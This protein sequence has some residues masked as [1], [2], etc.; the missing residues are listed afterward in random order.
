MTT[1][2]N[3]PS[4]PFGAGALNGAGVPGDLPDVMELTRLANEF[5]AN[6]PGYS[7]P[8]GPRVSGKQPAEVDVP[9]PGM[10]N[11]AAW[12]ASPSPTFGAPYNVP[13]SAAGMHVAPSFLDNRPAGIPSEVPGPGAVASYPGAGAVHSIAPEGPYHVPPS[14]SVT[15]FSRTPAPT[16]VA[17]KGP[18]G[19]PPSAGAA[20]VPGMHPASAIAPEGPY[21]VPPSASA[22][23]FSRTPAPSPVAH[24][25]PYGVPPSAAAAPVPQ[26]HVASSVTPERPYHV[27]PSASASPFSRTPAP[28]PVAPGDHTT[29]RHRLPP[30]PDQDSHPSIQRQERPT[31]PSPTRAPL[32]RLRTCRNRRRSATSRLPIPVGLQPFLACLRCFPPM[33]FLASIPG[34]QLAQA[35]CPSRAQVSHHSISL[36]ERIRSAAADGRPGWQECRAWGRILPSMPIWCAGISLS[37]ANW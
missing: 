4:D 19:V 13:H 1:S 36:M 16:P 14:A 2:M 34:L 5:Y 3:T 6:P 8:P 23:P 20:P 32:L 29:C 7:T 26:T 18:Y 28:T 22:T 17:P 31:M 12:P 9:P 10:G 37:W 25:G 35:P 21:H 33:I 15:P 27:P 11:S 30:V 24:R